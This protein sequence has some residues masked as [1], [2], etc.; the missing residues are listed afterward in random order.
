MFDKQKNNTSKDLVGKIN[1]IAEG[2]KI[3]GDIESQVDFRLDGELI[4][5]FSSGGKLVIGET[6]KIVGN[7]ICKNLDV[8]GYYEGKVEVQEL[9]SVKSKAVIRGEV[10]VGKLSV[11][12]G[13]EFTATCKMTANTR[14][15]EPINKK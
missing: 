8:E 14:G 4:G 12:P 3:K 9:L 10:S 6:G 11:E 15:A 7:I 2:T 1:R 13:A 5:N